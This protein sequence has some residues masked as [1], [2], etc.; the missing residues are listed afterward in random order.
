M[1]TNANQLSVKYRKALIVVVL[2]STDFYDINSSFNDYEMCLCVISL[3]ACDLDV[4]PYERLPINKNEMDYKALETSYDNINESY[5]EL[6][7]R[8]NE[9]L[10]H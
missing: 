4:L 1:C 3:C 10:I 2:R 9:V 7:T 8:S 5:D 6:L